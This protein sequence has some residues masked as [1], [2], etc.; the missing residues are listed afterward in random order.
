MGRY[1]DNKDKDIFDTIFERV[2]DG[3]INTASNV[4]IEGFS[5]WLQN[6]GKN[7]YT[8]E[9][10]WRNDHSSWKKETINIKASSQEDA[11]NYI[12]NSYPHVKNIKIINIE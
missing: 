9:Y 2:R 11:V 12:F 10:S 3:I 5:S 7:T 8:I 6:A 1:D 4:I